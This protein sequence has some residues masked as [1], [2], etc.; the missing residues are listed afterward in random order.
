[1]S[2]AQHGCCVCVCACMGAGV[3]ACMFGP[4][5]ERG[6]ATLHVLIF[7]CVYSK[8]LIIDPACEP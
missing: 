3:C 8:Q 5:A 2:E 1:M 4:R 6:L 7:T